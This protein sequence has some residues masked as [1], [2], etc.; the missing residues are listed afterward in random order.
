MGLLRDQTYIALG[1]KLRTEKLAKT[2]GLG[3]I[4]DSPLLNLIENSYKQG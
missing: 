2:P 3:K 1:N 4:S